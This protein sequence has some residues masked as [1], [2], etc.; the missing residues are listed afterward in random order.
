VE[1]DIR[2]L[3][4]RMSAEIELERRGLA[5]KEVA[6]VGYRPGE[7]LRDARYGLEED[8]AEADED[9]VDQP[10]S[11]NTGGVSARKAKVEDGDASEE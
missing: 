7:V 3:W 2:D 9:D 6:E 8:D 10:C 5:H 11:C 1:N 4:R